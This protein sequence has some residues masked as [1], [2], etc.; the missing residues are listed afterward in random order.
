MQIAVSLY[1]C[2][3][4][5]TW[6]LAPVV[7]GLFGWATGSRDPG[8]A[9]L[10]TIERIRREVKKLD[11]KHL[12]RLVVPP[13]RRL[14]RVHVELTLRDG[15]EKRRTAGVFPV[16][17]ERRAAGAER[18]LEVGY[19]P[20]HPTRW[21]E[22]REDTPLSEQV[23]RAY[24][25]TLDPEEDLDFLKAEPSDKLVTIRFDVDPPSLLDLLNDKPDVEQTTAGHSARLDELLR[26]A[27]NQT[28]RAAEG[29]LPT[30][31]AREPYR[32][33]LQ[34][35]LCGTLKAPVLVVG[36]PGSGKSTVIARAVSDLLHSDDFAAHQNLDRVHN[37]LSLRGR[38]IIAGMSYVGQWEARC[39]A[40]L[41]RARKKKLV[42]WAD[43]VHAWGSIGRTTVSERSLAD[44]F[45]GP[46]ARRDL[47]LIGECTPEQLSVL[48]HDAPGFAATFARV[49]VEPTTE[50]QT[51]GVM[52]HGSRRL[53]RELDVAFDS[54]CFR[55]IASA[56]STLTTGSAFPGKAL[57]PLDALARE[58][59]GERRNDDEDDEPAIEPR[60]VIGYFSRQ[61]GLP[62]TLLVAAHPLEPSTLVRELGQQIMGQPTALDAAADLVLGVRA[63]TSEPGRPYGVFL[64]TGPTGTGKTE[65]AKCIAEYLYGQSNRLVRFDMGELNTLDAP[66]Q[67]IGDRANP[68]GKLTRAVRA[69]PFSVLLFDEI[70]KA[71][72][73]VL[74]LMLQLFDDARLTDATGT[75]ADFTHTV[76]IMTSNLGSG[77]RRI[78]GFASDPDSVSQDVSKAVREFFAPELFNRIDRVVA[79]RPLE[80][81]TARDI[82]RKELAKLA[83]RPGLTERNV[84]VRV[85]D[86]VVDR[87]VED[88]YSHEYGARAV[89]RHIDR[90]VG[91]V[92]ARTL[93]S[94]GAAAM[95]LLWLHQREDGVGVYAEALA[96]AETVSGAG[97]VEPLLSADPFE[98]ER[99]VPDA[100]EE[101]RQIETDGRFEDLGAQ[102]S[103][104]LAG[105]RLGDE[106]AADRLFS[107]DAVVAHISRLRRRLESHAT[108][109][110]RLQAVERQRKRRAG[111][112]VAAD[113]YSTL[114][115]SFGKRRDRSEQ[116]PSRLVGEAERV[117]PG[118]KQQRLLGDLA[119]V[120]LLAGMLDRVE[121]QDQHVCSLELLRL[122]AQHES[123]RFSRGNPGLLE[124]LARAYASSRGRLDGAAAT[125]GDG[126]QETASTMGELSDLLEARPRQLA[127][128]LLGPGVTALLAG[129]HGCH[130]RRAVGV[131]PEIVRVRVLA[132]SHDPRGILEEHKR[133]RR[134]FE[135]ALEASGSLPPNPAA[136][137]PIVRTIIFDPAEGG[138]AT[139]SI[140]DYRLAHAASR[141]VRDLGELLRDF[142]LLDAG[143]STT[144]R[145]TP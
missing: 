70:E 82:A 137:L 126:R 28:A 107:L 74:N 58:R 7:P 111:E 133:A 135:R 9:R 142:W 98:L 116:R 55:S 29:K 52:L 30:G 64:F 23:R 68:E 136:L 95:K 11:R 114:G 22:V 32:S 140:E 42:L 75:V 41:Q 121:Q 46:L 132:G 85:T 62:E 53:E 33:R 21:F 50:P 60:D 54:R 24:G 118:K 27:V 104:E 73:S 44:F 69:Q 130:V 34:Q 131:G 129:E 20:L 61:T 39:M 83:A 89:K 87:V 96:E 84:F 99:F 80:R 115:A 2:K 49:R 76:I 48:E 16:V 97:D 5:S 124:W 100:L 72:P 65:L 112:A 91:D 79:F 143:R 109:D 17:L 93:V 26:V 71:H 15:P 92:L 59:A 101:L 25:R 123:R 56:A 138:P 117:R 119:E 134:A 12:C 14:E 105:F 3:R 19:H 38:H 18:L 45:R 122:A 57:G 128:R 86:A 125:L 63:K 77:E 94:D 8:K 139:A 78:R 110:A 113:D 4:S 120:R 40:L 66:G 106:G 36:P 141:R 67:L 127:L 1:Q 51:L 43:D 35:L 144:R 6:R 108:R 13:G 88:G 47:L 102:L 90:N 37:V 81:S 145:S 31:L 10:R 103:R